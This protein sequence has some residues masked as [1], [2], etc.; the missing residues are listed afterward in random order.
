M[1]ESRHQ[2]ASVSMTRCPGIRKEDIKM[3]RTYVDVIG[4]YYDS[5]DDLIV[6]AN[7]FGVR[8]AD[9][10]RVLSGKKIPRKQNFKDE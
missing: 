1:R 3:K 4:E 8:D 5:L 9:L 7:R 2:S 10:I 6:D